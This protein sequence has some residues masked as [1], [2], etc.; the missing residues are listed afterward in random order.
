MPQQSKSLI[1]AFL[2]GALIWSVISQ[3]SSSIWTG[4]TWQIPLITLV[5]VKQPILICSVL[6]I[7]RFSPRHSSFSDQQP[8]QI[9]HCITS[10][11]IAVCLP[12]LSYKYDQCL[13]FLAPIWCLLICFP[14]CFQNTWKLFK[15]KHIF[16]AA[17]CLAGFLFVTARGDLPFQSTKV[18]RYSL[19]TIITIAPS[20]YHNCSTLPVTAGPADLPKPV[21]PNNLSAPQVWCNW[22]PV[23]RSPSLAYCGTLTHG[24]SWTQVGCKRPFLNCS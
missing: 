22:R 24:S 13:A 7:S 6:H 4:G 16:M 1:T 10:S 12:N 5:F 20:S 19:H 14:L 17:S 2:P 21:M 3:P 18:G 9:H 23:L 8:Y 15:V 11:H